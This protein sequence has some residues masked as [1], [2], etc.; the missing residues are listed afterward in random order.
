MEENKKK[1]S[2][3]RIATLILLGF[4]II[5]LIFLSAGFAFFQVEN[6]D[7]ESVTHGTINL[8]CL[9]IE[10]T[11]EGTLSPDYAYPIKDEYALEHITPIKVKI[12]NTCEANLEDINYSLVLTTLTN[13]DNN[14]TSDKMRVNSKRS[15]NLV[16]ASEPS[17]YDNFLKPSYLSS[18]SELTNEYSKEALESDILNREKDGAKVFE[19]YT[20]V[21]SRVIDENFIKSNSES[22]YEIQL[23]I[24]YY[25]VDSGVYSG[26]GHD[27]SFDNSTKNS[28]FVGALS[29]VANPYE[30]YTEPPKSTIDTLRE[31]DSGNYLSTSL[32]G[33]M[34]RYQGL[35][36]DEINN[37]ICLGDNCCTT[38]SCPASSDDDMYRIIG[39]TQ[40]GEMKVIKKT[41]LTDSVKWWS[42]YKTDIKWPQSLPYQKLNGK[43]ADGTTNPNYNDT[44]SYYY[45]LDANIKSKIVNN[46][47]WLYGDTTNNGSYNGDTIY[48][49]ES[50]WSDRIEAPLGLMYL[51]DYYYAYKT[52]DDD[53]GKPE[54]YSNAKNSWIHLSHNETTYPSG[55][56]GYEWTMSRYGL[57]PADSIYRAW[58]V[59]G[60]GDV[61]RDYLDSEHALRPSFYLASDIELTG[62]GSLIEPFRITSLEG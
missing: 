43:S 32:V 57:N 29:V 28:T 19:G 51:S 12:T 17:S 25:E 24:D 3:L 39:I 44:N 2:K 26:S 42:D 55:S 49:I 22:V 21:D 34:Y 62:E 50:G 4:L 47:S 33:D 35:Y 8:D 9:Q 41:A 13:S 20:V 53:A 30:K 48:G 38:E 52:S 23:W 6:T 60:L 11:E 10:Y 59:T 61:N 14:I 1:K 5:S 54:N 45:S 7:G 46:H 31:K 56:S 37:Y 40:S 58:R 15:L 36:T 16:P 18:L 27:G